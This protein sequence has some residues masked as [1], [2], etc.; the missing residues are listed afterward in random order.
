[1]SAVTEEVEAPT[2]PTAAWTHAD[3]F[4]AAAIAFGVLLTALVGT[5]VF[6]RG[7]DWLLLT[8]VSRPGFG[9]SDLFVPYASHVMPFG[10]SVF[11]AGRALGGATPRVL[12]AT[13]AV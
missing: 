1:M 4:A 6:L 11:W 5:Q 9:P 3:T 12:P 8:I 13:F 7:D 10:L 2:A